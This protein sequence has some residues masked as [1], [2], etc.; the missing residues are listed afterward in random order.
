MTFNWTSLVRELNI[1]YDLGNVGWHWL[2]LQLISNQQTK[3]SK[4]LDNVL[5]LHFVKIVSKNSSNNFKLHYYPTLETVL[6]RI[7][8]VSVIDSVIKFY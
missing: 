5:L 7:L 3:R 8:P 6:Q 2:P 4:L 1:R